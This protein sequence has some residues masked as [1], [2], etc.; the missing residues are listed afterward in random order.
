MLKQIDAFSEGQLLVTLRQVT[1]GLAYLHRC[2][3]FMFLSM[4]CQEL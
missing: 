1:E 2:P 3:D 4:P